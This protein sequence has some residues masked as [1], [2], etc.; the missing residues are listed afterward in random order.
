MIEFEANKVIAVAR[1]WLGVPYRHQSASRERGVDCI[2]FVLAVG[3]EL[4]VCDTL[5]LAPY[6]MIN[7]PRKIVALLEEHGERVAAQDGVVLFWGRR[8]GVPTHFGFRSRLDGAI[9]VIHADAQLGRVVEH[10]IPTEQ[11]PLIHSHW[12]FKS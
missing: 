8:L 4:G 3:R 2:Q 1:S 9:A 7:S 12:W 6:P 11:L 10:R 5:P